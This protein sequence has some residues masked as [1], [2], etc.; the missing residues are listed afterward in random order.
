MAPHVKALNPRVA[1]TY[2]HTYCTAAV[3]ELLWVNPLNLT[4]QKKTVE[5]EAGSL[6]KGSMHYGSFARGMCVL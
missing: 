3:P 4:G 5:D 1:W 2:R 6:A